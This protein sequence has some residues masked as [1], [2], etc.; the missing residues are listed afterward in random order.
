MFTSRMRSHDDSLGMPP[1]WMTASTPA[2]AA[3]IAARSVT[4]AVSASSPG[5]SGLEAG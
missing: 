3:V 5:P 2:Q 1:R 4:D